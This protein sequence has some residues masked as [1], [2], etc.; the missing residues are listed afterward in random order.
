MTQD[1]E[2]ADIVVA[3]TVVRSGGFAGLTRRWGV[4]APP[5]DAKRWRSLVDDCPWDEDGIRAPEGADRFAWSVRA[6]LPDA[7][8][9]ADLTETQVAGPWRILIDAVREASAP[10]SPASPTRDAPR[11]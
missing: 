1:P 8:L 11:R 7:S 2:H 4:S 3:V 10:P 6:T 5:A 9:R